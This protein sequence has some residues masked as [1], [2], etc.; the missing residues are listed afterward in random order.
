MIFEIAEGPDCDLSETATS[1]AILNGAAAS[2]VDTAQG[3]VR[4]DFDYNLNCPEA[5][6]GNV[7]MDMAAIGFHSGINGW[8]TVKE[9]IPRVPKMASTTEIIYFL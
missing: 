1:H 4:L 9:W 6:S 5:D 2:C 8:S 7:L 3:R